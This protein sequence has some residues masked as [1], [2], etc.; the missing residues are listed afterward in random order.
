L[1]I[2]FASRASE[3]E[4]FGPWQTTRTLPGPFPVTAEESERKSG[5]LPPAAG[6]T[7]VSGRG[8]GQ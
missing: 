7:E 8:S 2:D 1:A 3:Y 4:P 6:V 5:T